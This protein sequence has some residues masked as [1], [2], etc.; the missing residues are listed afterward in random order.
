MELVAMFF[1]IFSVSFVCFFGS[2]MSCGFR[3]HRGGEV[4]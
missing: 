1:V 2:T 3:Q 4:T